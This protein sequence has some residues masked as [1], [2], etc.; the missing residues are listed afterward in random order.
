MELGLVQKIDIDDEMQQAYLDYAM[1]VIV[2]RALP[3]ARDGL[4][5]VHRRILYAMYDMGLRPNTTFKKSARIVGEVLGKY[6]PHSDMAVYEAMAR[7]AQDF[8]M[9]YPLVEGQGNFGSMDG[10]PPAAMRYTE[11]RLQNAAI[12]MLTDLEKETVNFDE[13]FD[14]SLTEPTVLP[15]AIPNLLL[16]GATGI[17]VGMA[18][19]IPPHNLVEI[20]DALTFMLHKWRRIEDIT[21]EDL[22]QFVKG[23][24]FPTGG[25]I[26]QN[27]GSDNLLSAYS[28][29][30][31]R[32]VVRASTHVE[33]MSRGRN[34]IIVT[35]LPFMTN[36]SSLIER[37]AS[38][39]REEKIEGIADLR[40]E[41][42]RQGMRI[43]IEL[44]KSA[45]PQE[46]LVDLYKSTPMQSTFSLI[47]LALVDGEP[48]LL[49]LKQALR[50]YIEHRL[51]IIQLRSEY[52]LARAEERA[53]ILEGLQI[54]LMNI[55]EVIRIIR[56]SQR[57]DTAKASLR[58]RFKLTAIQAQAILD[59][60]LRRLASLERKKIEEEYRA[61]RAKIRQ[62]KS[63]LRSPKKM[64]DVIVEELQEVKETYGDRRRTQIAQIKDGQKKVEFLTTTDLTP[65]KN[66]WLVVGKNGSISRTQGN[67]IP[68]MSG[69]QAPL[70]LVQA[71][72]RDTLY[73]VDKKGN[74]AAIPVHAVP[75]SD[76][77]ALGI[78]IEKVCDLAGV[79]SLAYLFTLPSKEQLQD[80]SA[81]NRHILTVTQ[82][83]MVKKSSVSELPGPSAGTFPLVKV[84]K[85]DQ[86]Q[87]VR[88]THGKDEILLMSGN[89]MAI[90]FKEEEVRAMG[91][92][93]AGVMGMKLKKGE[94]IIGAEVLPQP[95]DV[96]MIA[97]DGTGKRVAIKDF[98]SQGRYGQ[99][100]M[101]WKIPSNVTVVGIT[102]GR[103]SKRLIVSSS[104]LAPK[105]LRLDSASLLGRTARGKKI[106]DL[107]GNNKLTAINIPHRR[108][109][110]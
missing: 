31:G 20:V 12:H 27:E 36:K 100:V 86:L 29:G 25:I 49:S 67:K 55:D 13:N 88:L 91:L 21:V 66:I 9:R 90:R 81:R 7:M 1:S 101:A 39:A 54:A 56:R 64:R 79:K 53:H 85:G 108:F 26:L 65:E 40:D 24:D 62:L 58:K 17:A 4:K 51:E 34:R 102:V 22:M 82:Q 30:R 19:S 94:Q 47:M 80:A 46:V 37:I 92:V 2:S 110:K 48:R 8:S 71:N 23:P 41:S 70:W 10:D 68:R 96:F 18:T 43:V 14:G 78:P 98:P 72:T 35:E 105:T 16:N 106:I 42:D 59:M 60:P 74:A 103:G 84:N 76:D 3:D 75:E 28:T 45:D 107:K 33:E 104:R 93:A 73:L 95:G 32:V 77:L 38:M 63:L 44:Y 50:V 97:S 61:L 15:A 5:P 69:R 11:A 6:H 87:F 52:D 89:G 83:G 57:V 109:F 99:G